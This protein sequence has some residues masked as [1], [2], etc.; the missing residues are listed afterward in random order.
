MIRFL[1][2][3]IVIGAAVWAGYQFFSPVPVEAARVPKFK[4]V[5]T[6]TVPEK[7]DRWITNARTPIDATELLAT[8]ET[9][10]EEVARRFQNRP[11]L[12]TGIVGNVATSGLGGRRAIVEL[13]RTPRTQLLAVYDLDR[14]AGTQ[15]GSSKTLGYKFVV[16]GPELFLLN[17]SRRTRDSFVQAKTPYKST[18]TFDRITPSAVLLNAPLPK[19][20]DR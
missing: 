20:L 12:I 1:L 13:A 19:G 6:E 9:H 10:P 2:V 14:H 17:E 4:P 5:Q 18:V 8:C 16:S 7:L 15:M 3:L 11:F